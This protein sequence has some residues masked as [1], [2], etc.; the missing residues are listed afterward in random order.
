M[1]LPRQSMFSRLRQVAVDLLQDI[2]IIIFMPQVIE[3]NIS[4]ILVNGDD[5]C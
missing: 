1:R 5:S 3:A 2:A 4:V